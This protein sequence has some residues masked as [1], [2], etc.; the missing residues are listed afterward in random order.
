VGNEEEDSPPQ[1]RFMTLGVENYTLPVCRIPIEQF[2]TAFQEIKARWDASSECKEFKSLMGTIQLPIITKIVAFGCG[3]LAHALDRPQ[4]FDGAVTALEDNGATQHAFI[5][6]LRECLEEKQP[7]T[8]IECLAQDPGYLDAD[9]QVLREAGIMP[10][11]DPKGFLEVDDETIVFSQIPSA[12]VRQI[13]ADIATPA[14]MIWK[15]VEPAGVPPRQW[16]RFG[17]ASLIIVPSIR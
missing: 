5:L 8:A 1:A 17:C 3:T 12:P 13:I 11:E 14:M 4:N 7:G 9:N 6:T 2:R 16:Y 15:R 10:V